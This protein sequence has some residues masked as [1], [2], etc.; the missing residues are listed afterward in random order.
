MEPTDPIEKLE[1]WRE[2]VRKVALFDG[3]QG[4]YSRQ[5][6]ISA[7]KLSYYKGHFSPK[8]SFAKVV[9]KSQPEL[10][11][12]QLRVGPEESKVKVPDAK[13]LAVFLKELLR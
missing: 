9:P 10:P 5:N 2:H 3:T 4:E 11:Q 6:G 12:S 13:W 1:F 8:S 7:S